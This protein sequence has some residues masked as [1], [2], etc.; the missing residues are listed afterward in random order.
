MQ[1]SILAVATFLGLTLAAPANSGFVR[2]PVTPK[3]LA[4][5][6]PNAISNPLKDLN[7]EVTVELITAATSYDVQIN[8]GNQNITVDLDTGSPFLWVWSADSEYCTS[9]DGLFACTLQGDYHTEGASGKNTGSKFNI[10]YGLGSASGD[11]W[12]DSATLGSAT[13]QNFPFGVNSGAF[14]NNSMGVFGIGPNPDKNTSY[15]AQLKEQGII[16][17][18]AYG[19]SLGPLTSLEDPSEITFGAVN[20]GRFDGKLKTVKIQNDPYHYRVGASASVNGESILDNGQVILDSGTT[21]TYLNDD[22]YAKFNA[23]LNKSGLKIAVST[24]GATAGLPTFNCSEGNK[25]NLS[26]DFDG[27]IVKANATDLSIPVSIFTGAD[28]GQC[29]LGVFPGGEN[30]RGLNLLGDTFLRNVYAVYDLDRS[31]VSIAQLA[32]GKKDNYVVITGDI[33]D[34]Y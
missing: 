6:N 21:L 10:T 16:K 7:G 5:K 32:K 22:A 9:I 8:L 27:Q 19:L 17:R 24:E 12:S 29:V 30:L 33:P 31:E 26:V 2:V 28:N 20:T 18:N 1:F 34:S 23:T 3:T 11:V 13:V 4:K 25:L 15:S 14:A